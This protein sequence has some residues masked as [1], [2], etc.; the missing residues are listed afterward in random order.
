MKTTFMIIQLVIAIVLSLVILLEPPRG[1]GL[2]AIGGS[3]KLFHVGKEK[4]RRLDMIV[5][6]AGGA[7][8]VLAGI[9]AWAM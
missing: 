3:A 7:F 4:E 6:I 5:A 1:E 8:F 2:G 9:L